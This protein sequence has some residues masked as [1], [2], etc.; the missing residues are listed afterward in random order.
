MPFGVTRLDTFAVVRFAVVAMRFVVVS[1][2][3]FSVATCKFAVTMLA[4]LLTAVMF[5]F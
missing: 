5:I 3:G 1:C 4:R 2:A